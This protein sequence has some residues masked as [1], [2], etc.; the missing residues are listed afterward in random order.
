[1]PVNA[2]DAASQEAAMHD[3]FRRA[4][5]RPSE[6]DFVEL[7]AT[8]TARGDPTEANWIGKTFQ[9]DGEILVG[10]VKGNIG[11]VSNLCQRFAR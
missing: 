1:M 2:P 4:G 10:S 8:G 5:R 6:V 7:H 11:Q 3:A 9:R